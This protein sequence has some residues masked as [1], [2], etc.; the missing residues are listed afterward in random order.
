[1]GV[2]ERVGGHRTLQGRSHRGGFPV[3][4]QGS[5]HGSQSPRGAGRP[6][7]SV[8]TAAFFLLIHSLHIHHSWSCLVKLAWITVESARFILPRL[9][10]AKFIS[11]ISLK[12][13]QA[14]IVR[15]F[16][17]SLLCS[18]DRAIRCMTCIVYDGKL[19]VVKTGRTVR[20]EYLSLVRTIVSRP[21]SVWKIVNLPS[22]VCEWFEDRS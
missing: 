17:L 19:G 6:R 22:S 18:L 5:E 15:Y 7:S 4:Q 11:F 16:A 20:F 2:Q 21:S 3:S 9:Y 14:T 10:S 13:N 1:M 12:T 8:S